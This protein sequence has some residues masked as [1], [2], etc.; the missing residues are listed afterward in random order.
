[1]DKYNKFKYKLVPFQMQVYYI[2]YDYLGRKYHC[3]IEAMSEQEA[4]GIFRT[5]FEHSCRI[6]NVKTVADIANETSNKLMN[7]IKSQLSI[8]ENIN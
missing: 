1:M 6:I 2:Q 4:R 3:Q 5:K 8:N 7:I